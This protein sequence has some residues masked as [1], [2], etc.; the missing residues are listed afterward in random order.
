[1]GDITYLY[2]LALG[3]TVLLFCEKFGWPK[4]PCLVAAS[5]AAAELHILP[6]SIHIDPQILLGVFLPPLLFNS[7]RSIPLHELKENLLKT[8]AFA[9]FGTAITIA[10]V[11]WFSYTYLHMALVAALL[12]SAAGSPTDPPGTIKI[13]EERNAPPELA[14]ITELE[15]LLND[16]IG[17]VF[18]S[19]FT[20]ML[21]GES[22]TVS[23]GLL[24]FTHEAV[25]GVMIGIGIGVAAGNLTSAFDNKIEEFF[26]TLLVAI[27]TYYAADA[28]GSS[29]VLAV[30]AVGMALKD[31][32]DKNGGWSPST[33]NFVR[34]NWT[35]LSEVSNAFI[36]MLV[37]SHIGSFLT[38]EAFLPALVLSVVLLLARAVTVFSLSA[39]LGFFEK[40]L[41]LSWQ[42]TLIVGG[43]RGGLGIA[44]LLTLPPSDMR[45]MLLARLLWVVL[46]SL[47][48]QAL[49]IGPVLKWTGLVAESQPLTQLHLVVERLRAAEAMMEEW[50]LAERDYAEILDTTEED[51]LNIKFLE[52]EIS[53]LTDERD[54]ILRQN[55]ELVS[56]V[57]TE[58]KIRVIQAGINSVSKASV[59]SRYAKDEVLASLNKRLKEIS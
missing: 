45:E 50:L 59:S 58:S 42:L 5:F 29:G 11:A 53:Q 9:L 20:G 6:A 41:P 22:L 14:I 47:C 33:E 43:L 23:H 46:I 57:I 18:F 37:G 21:V 17:V 34:E 13:M 4:L 24:E 32:V 12:W 28:V 1:M 35:M 55:P 7:S 54:R 38:L 26:L 51:E 52:A 30:V 15:S 27:G 39:I 19:I 49:L 16:G 48:G 3:V 44:M 25:F 31:T 36:F 2:L 40:R 56:R 8:I 10:I